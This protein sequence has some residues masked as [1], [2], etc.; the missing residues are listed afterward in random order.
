MSLLSLYM[1]CYY[2]AMSKTSFMERKE[3]K[4][5]QKHLYH[6]SYLEAYK[7]QLEKEGD[8]EANLLLEDKKSRF[9][10]SEQKYLSRAKKQD[11]RQKNRVWEIDFLRAIAIFIMLIDHLIFDFRNLFPN[12]FDKT[13]YLNVS[14]FNTMYQFSYDYWYHP[15]RI[16]IRLFGLVLFAFLIG[17]NTR[18][19]RNNLKRGLI[20]T[21]CGFLMSGVFA[22]GAA[23]G[24]TGYAIMNILLCYGLSL[25]IY[26]AVEPLK[27]KFEKNWKWIC[28]GIAV[29]I[30][31]LWGIVRYLTLPSNINEK[32]RN[33]WFIYNGYAL[34]IPNISSLK[35]VSFGDILKIIIGVT[36]FGDDWLGLFPTLGYVFLGAFVGH[37]VYESGVS[38]L[39]RFDK[40][41]EISTNEKFNRSTKGF[42]FFG[43]HTIWIYLFHQVVYILIILLVAGLFI[44]VPL[45]K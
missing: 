3:E 12:I 25:L 44:G 36:Y 7:Y 19:S 21:G 8:V 41:Y 1:V 16:G 39:S 38:L 31:I 24:I 34:S 35:G 15:V 10:R 14:F 26:S 27:K 4:L 42:L 2:F 45:A 6:L 20:L 23:I 32:Y 33:F 11:K 13:S 22:I 37:S 40:N 9:N 29:I 18:F 5:H 28:L 30:F 17:I 43:H